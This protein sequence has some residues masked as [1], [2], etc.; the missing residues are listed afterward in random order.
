MG[1]TKS[2][3]IYWLLTHVCVYTLT[4][5]LTLIFFYDVK[6]VFIFSL[7]TFVTHFLT[8]YGTSK[9]TSKLYLQKKYYGFPAFFSVI[10]LDQLLHQIQLIIC[11]E[12]ILK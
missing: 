1:T 4:F 5:M 8:D 11:Y 9:W 10:G 3:N 12:Y 7:I 2:K 6:G